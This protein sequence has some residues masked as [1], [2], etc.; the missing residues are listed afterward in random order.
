MI[1]T[2]FDKL[3]RILEPRSGTAVV[4]RFAMVVCLIALVNLGFMQAYGLSHLVT[5]LYY[6]LHAVFVGGPFVLFALAV[7]VFQIQL[8]RKLS[9]LSRKDGLTGLNNRRT[10]LEQTDS[11]R[12]DCKHGVL[13]LIDADNFKRI[14][15]TYGHQTGDLCLKRIAET[16]RKNVRHDDIIGRVGG[17]EFALFLRNTS[18]EQARAVGERLTKPIIFRPANRSSARDLRVTLSVGA[19]MNFA[20]QPL[21]TL[22]ARADQALYKAKADGRARLVVWTELLPMH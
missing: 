14:N 13:L 22:F 4:G 18:L 12:K 19:A 10:F 3:M 11:R 1:D 9:F 20:D 15:D 17:E 5:P 8:Q 7:I 6:I 16:L 21:E 2:W